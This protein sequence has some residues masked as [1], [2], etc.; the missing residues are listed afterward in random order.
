MNT[1]IAGYDFARSLA[2]FG[3]VV[4][5]FRGDV[6]HVDLDLAYDLIHGGATATFL[7]LGGIGISLLKQRNQRTNDAHKSRG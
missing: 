3:L 1:R 7:V 6:E 5:N 2:V 4:A